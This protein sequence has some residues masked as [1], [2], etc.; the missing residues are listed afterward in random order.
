MACFEINVWTPLH[1]DDN[2][3]SVDVEELVL[4][5]VPVS[6]VLALEQ[7]HPD[8]LI[9]HPR[10]IDGRPR[11]VDRFYYFLQVYGGDHIGRI[12]EVKG[13]LNYLV[14]IGKRD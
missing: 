13:I 9:V 5:R 14:M 12:W 3:P 8:D 11:S 1:V 7:S 2:P 4:V 10:H 6:V